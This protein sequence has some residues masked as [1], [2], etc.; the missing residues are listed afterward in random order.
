M[1]QDR[2][3]YEAIFGSDTEPGDP[4]PFDRN[5]LSPQDALYEEVYSEV[6][7]L[8]EDLVMCDV[9]GDEIKWREKDGVYM[10]RRCGRTFSRREF[11]EY[12]GATPPGEECYD[13]DNLFPG[14]TWCPYGHLE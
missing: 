9:C 14:C 4:L 5:G 12:I 3:E 8:D 11:F 13:C 2:E 6:Y 7:D 10:C 1:K